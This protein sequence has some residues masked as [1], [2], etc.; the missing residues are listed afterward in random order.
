MNKKSIFVAS[1]TRWKRINAMQDKDIDLSEIPEITAE[2]I[3]RAKLRVGGKQAPRG[4]VRINVV[5]DA[6]VLA[7]FKAQAGAHGYQK[8]INDRLK[9]GIREHNLEST[10][11]RVIREELRT[12][13]SA[14]P[15]A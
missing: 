6:E 12:P 14:K 13:R 9:S 7:Y 4:K 11:R 2:Q 5:L 10:L 8:L 3:T 15:I 1:R